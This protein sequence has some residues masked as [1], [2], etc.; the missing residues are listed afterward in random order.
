MSLYS[1]MIAVVAMD[2]VHNPSPPVFWG[3]WLHFHHCLLQGVCW[4]EVGAD[5]QRGQ[6]SLQIFTPALLIWGALGLSLLFWL[7]VFCL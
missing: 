5:T 3:M 4:G 6:D 2:L 1:I 7:E